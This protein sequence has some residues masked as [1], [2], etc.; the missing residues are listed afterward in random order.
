MAV[1]GCI[2][3]GFQI[4]YHGEPEGTTPIEH[5]FCH[6]DDW[7]KFEVENLTA[8]W[9]ESNHEESFSYAWRC[10]RCGTFIFFDY[11]LKNIGTYTSNE[12]F[13]NSPMQEPAEFGPFWNDFQWFDITES[14]VTAAEVLTKFPGN[15]WLE[16]N[17]DEMRI[18]EDAAKTKCIQ[19]FR[20]F[21]RPE[22]VTVAT[23]SLESFRKMLLSYDDEVDFTY[24]KKCYEFIKE[25]LTDSQIKIIVNE[26]YDLRILKYS[27]V[28]NIDEDFTEDLINAKIFSDG[29]SI[30]EAQNEVEL[31]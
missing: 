7:N 26:D 5:I 29:R 28:V 21:K 2:F 22:K 14:D 11:L 1:R 8:D 30:T 18:Y 24:N 10:P 25:K 12:I 13:S 4:R 19:Q 23:M 16:K 31:C 17:E 9:L 6:L 27:K 3:C 15:Y 20:K